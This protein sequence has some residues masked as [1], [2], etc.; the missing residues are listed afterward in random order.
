MRN[1][2]GGCIHDQR[3][4]RRSASVLPRATLSAFCNWRRTNQPG[5]CR[6]IV[7]CCLA[8]TD[9]CS[10][11]EHRPADVVAQ[12][13]IVEHELADRLW[14]PGPLP[15]AL[16]SPCGL[17]LAFRRGGTSGL[18]RIGGRAEIVRGNMG[19]DGGLAR[20][21]CGVPW[22]PAEVS[23]CGHRVTARS[24]SLHHRDLPSH[25]SAS[26]LDRLTWSWVLRLSRLEE[27]KHVLRARCG[28]QSEEV[29]IRI[30]EGPAAADRHETGVPDL[31]KDHG[32]HS[33]CRLAAEAGW[34]L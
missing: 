13:L 16:T 6:R 33:F 5:G 9:A 2:I 10:A 34:Q 3:Q 1:E 24:T 23:G 25:P 18:D 17:V 19:N 20:S 14:Q 15:L 8:G 32:G 4:A 28:P 7:P 27:A 11:V 26:M 12:P 22:C 21:K 29:M 31:R 30:G